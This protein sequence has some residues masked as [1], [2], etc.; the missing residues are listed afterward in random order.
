MGFFRKLFTTATVQ[1]FPEFSEFTD[2]I[3]GLLGS[4]VAIMENDMQGFGEAL[5]RF[6]NSQAAGIKAQLEA[7]YEGGNC[8]ARAMRHF[9]R[10]AKAMRDSLKPIRLKN[11]ELVEQKAAVQAAQ[12]KAK[13]SRAAVGKAEDALS[14]AER[15]GNQVEVRSW[16]AKLEA[17]RRKADEDE[18]AVDAKQAAFHE[19]QARYPAEFIDLFATT[20]MRAVNAKLVELA[21][22]E[23][24]GRAILDASGRFEKYEDST[25]ERMRKRLDELDAIISE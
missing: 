9:F 5:K 14:R 20:V 22:L 17:A 7:V 8:Q 23:E 18:S 19:F 3:D 1:R 25:L 4:G 6:C 2:A 16:T 12:D 24:A 11:S 21:E 15:K 13:A 10:D